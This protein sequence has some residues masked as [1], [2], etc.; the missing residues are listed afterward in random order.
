MLANTEVLHEKIAVLCSRVRD[1]EDAL[2]EAHR[3]RSHDMHPLL[4]PELLQI[5]RPLERDTP[6]APKELEAEAAEAID[7]VGSLYAAILLIV[8]SVSH[9][10]RRSISES[11]GTKFY[12]T[13]ANAWVSVLVAPC[14]AMFGAD[15]FSVSSP[16]ASCSLEPP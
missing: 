10:A 1:L 4:V 5:K 6:D 12:G 3:A 11:G 13:A 2:T 9:R 7:A 8:F 14:N 15:L 16:G